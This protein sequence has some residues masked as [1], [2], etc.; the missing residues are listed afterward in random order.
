MAN[1]VT[2]SIVSELYSNIVQSAL[3]TYSEQ[4]VIRPV[5]RNYDMTGTP[6][7]TAQ[8]PKYPAITAS[9]LTDGTD[10]S[11]NTAFNTTS[12]TMSAAERG[13]KITLTDLAKETAQEDV[14]AAIGRQ[15]GE[16]MVN[17]VDGEIAA[18]FPS[19]SNRVGAAGDA[20]TAETIFKSV[21]QL[22]SQ[23]ARGQVFVV[24]HPFQAMD[25][26]IQLAGAGNTNMANPPVVGNTVL[27]SG[28]IGSL[29][30]AIILESNNVGKDTNDSVSGTGNFVGCAF[31]QDAIGYM[32]KRNIRVE[33]QRDASLRADEIVG[34][35]AYATAELF[36]EYG[37]GILG[38]ASLT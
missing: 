8:V 37:V 23:N 5:V 13:A 30:G 26:K 21:G 25:L 12:I 10:L 6:G 38:K 11:A 31:T 36:D 34:S 17:K 32:V 24:L 27:T 16:A 1:E 29:G 28:V 20:I 2:S 33:T 19:F 35:M 14:A 15:L 4:A 18:L 3:Y 22:R 7:L 9:D